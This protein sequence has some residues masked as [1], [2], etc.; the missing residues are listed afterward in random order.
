MYIKQFQFH[1]V[2]ISI[3]VNWSIIKTKDNKIT[4]FLPLSLTNNISVYINVTHL[5]L[6]TKIETAKYKFASVRCK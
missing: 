4:I 6:I 3:R 5:Y 2:S 1:L